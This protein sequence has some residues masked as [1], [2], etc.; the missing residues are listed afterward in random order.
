MSTL[1][2]GRDKFQPR[3][4]PCVFMGYPFGK[5]AYKVM[6]METNKFHVSRDVVFH[7]EIFPFA[8]SPK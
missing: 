3:A 6:D 4:K 5:K 1:K 8:A 7:E 2:Q